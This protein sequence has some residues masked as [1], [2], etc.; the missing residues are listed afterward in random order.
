MLAAIF[1]RWMV[2]HHGH[3]SRLPYGSLRSA[4]TEPGR[5]AR[6]FTNTRKWQPMFCRRRWLRLPLLG[7][8]YAANYDR[9]QNISLDINRP[10]HGSTQR[11][12]SANSAPEVIDQVPVG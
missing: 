11:P 8:Q 12:R 10:S 3:P 6:R 5:D 7:T 1:S 2:L 9:P 4:L